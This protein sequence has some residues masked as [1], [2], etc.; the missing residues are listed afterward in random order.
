MNALPYS[1]V[2]KISLELMINTADLG[3]TSGGLVHSF[4]EAAF[5]LV[6]T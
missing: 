2:E 6:D 5:L 3:R 4:I 1:E